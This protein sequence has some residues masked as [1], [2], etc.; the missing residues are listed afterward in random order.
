MGIGAATAQLLL[1]EGATVVGVARTNRPPEF[2]QAWSRSGRYR[3]VS[4]DVRQRET[5]VRAVEAVADS[6]LR[7]GLVNNAGLDHTSPLLDIDIA[8]L[9]EVMDV[10]FFGA[11]TMMQVLAQEMSLRGGGSIVNVTSRLASI[12]L[13]TMGG[14]GAS[15]GALASLTRHAAVELA[16]RGIVV[17][18]V[19][20][21]MT[22]TP[23]YAQWLAQS[24]DPLATEQG[25]VADIPLGRVATA[26]D[27]ASAIAFFLLPTSGYVTGASLAVDGG[28]TAK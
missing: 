17:N 20:P 28:Y 8:E 18:A 25:V 9:R 13:P 5:A 16:P 2:A 10:N 27:V 22:S 7:L 19:A 3:H 11:L 1:A 4:G 26:Q 23:L 15:K 24:S 12:G 14:Y 6:S 21:G